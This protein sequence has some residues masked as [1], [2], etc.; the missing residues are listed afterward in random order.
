MLL[1]KNTSEC[2]LRI[3]DIQGDHLS[4]Y[5]IWAYGGGALCEGLSKES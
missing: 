2:R 5:G 4:A 3:F 1:K